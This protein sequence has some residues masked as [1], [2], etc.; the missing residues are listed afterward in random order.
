MKWKY[1]RLLAGTLAALSLFSGVVRAYAADSDKIESAFSRDA[2]VTIQDYAAK[3]KWN[4]DLIRNPPN[5]VAEAPADRTWTTTYG[6][7]TAIWHNDFQIKYYI[8][9]SLANV[10]H[11]WNLEYYTAGNGGDVVSA[12]MAEYE[13]GVTEA[14][15]GHMKYISW[16]GEGFDSDTAWCCI[17]VSWCAWAAYG[18]DYQSIIPK[19]ASVTAMCNAF[20]A[21]GREYSPVG[22]TPEPGDLI[23]FYFQTEDY[24]GHHIGIVQKVENGRVYTIEGNS[25]NAVR[26]NNYALD[27]SRIKVY[28]RPAYPV[29]EEETDPADPADPTIDPTVD[30]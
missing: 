30:T 19:N 2:N 15:G 29:I 13:L 21:Q 12:A 6:E 20:R 4:F 14:S 17:F 8:D 24:T 7:G 27:D 5:P 23:V 26:N 10:S 3:Y 18:D 25:G 16:Y 11:L 9:S 28:L 22:F 1:R